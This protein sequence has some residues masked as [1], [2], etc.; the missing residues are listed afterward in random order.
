MKHFKILVWFNSLQVKWYI[1][2]SRKNIVYELL[3]KLLN[4]LRLSDF[5]KSEN[6]EKKMGGGRAY[7]PVSLLGKQ[8]QASKF[9]ALSSFAWFSDIASLV[10]TAI[11]SINIFL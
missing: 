8:K 11:V 9:L 10:L 7:Y 3:H 6:Y 5:R 2:S 4:D 1:K